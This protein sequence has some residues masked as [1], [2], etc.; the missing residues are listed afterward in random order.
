MPLLSALPLTAYQ[1]LAIVEVT[2]DYDSSEA[3]VVKL[4]RGKACETGAD[5]LVLLENRK[6]GTDLPPMQIGEH[7]PDPGVGEVGHKGRF[8]NSVAIVYGES[9]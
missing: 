7:A 5:A 8:L 9:R 4:A 6:Q 3:E 2:A 1:E